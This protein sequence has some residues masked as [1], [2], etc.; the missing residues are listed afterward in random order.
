MTTPLTNTQIPDK[1][2]MD[3]W[4]RQTYLG[5]T[6]VLPQD[7]KA[8][9]NTVETPVAYLKN[10]ATSDKSLF[11]FASRLSS[12]LN[13]VQVRFYLASTV[14]VIG[15]ATGAINVRTGSANTSVALGY[16][17]STFTSNGTQLTV[18]PATTYGL[19]SDVLVILDPG[20][21]L[22]ATGKQIGAGT[23]NV[24]VQLAWYEI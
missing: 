23:S 17:A 5:N 18:L 13:P 12:D 10:P 22:L 21:T 19:S 2:I 7:G 3:I 9:T 1:S 6:F 15:T 20:T 16:L 4:G 8:L 24:Y 14:N 11:V